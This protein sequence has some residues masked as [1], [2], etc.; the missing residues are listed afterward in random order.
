MPE[1][2]AFQGEGGTPWQEGE[3][4]KRRGLHRAL[5]EPLLAQKQEHV[6]QL[7]MELDAKHIIQ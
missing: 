6:L 5:P 7:L 1:E 4:V 2:A 3:G